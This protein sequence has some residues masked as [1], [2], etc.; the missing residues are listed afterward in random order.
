MNNRTLQSLI[1]HTFLFGATTVSLAWSGLAY[2]YGD[3]SMWAPIVNAVIW[4]ASLCGAGLCYRELRV[5]GATP[6]Q[7]AEEQPVNGLK[8]SC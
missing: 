4:L 1:V 5:I 2:F 6:D 8:P 3:G 7:S